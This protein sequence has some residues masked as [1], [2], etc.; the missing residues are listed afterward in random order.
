MSCE[1]KI[2]NNLTCFLL[3]SFPIVFLTSCA[4]A[5]YGTVPISSSET[6]T[7]AAKTT[8]RP[9]ER[10]I[11]KPV[12]RPVIQPFQKEQPSSGYQ[13]FKGERKYITASWYGPDFHGKP[14]ACGE[15]FNMHALT[16]AH[17]EYPFGTKLRVVNSQNSK[18]VECIV[19]DR[20]PFIAGRDLD[21]S[22]AAAKKID[23]VGPG[24]S[25]VMIEPIGRDLRYVKYIR[26]GVSDGVLTIQIGSFK[27]ESNARRLKMALELRYKNAYIMEANVGG[28]KYYRVRIG[29]YNSKGDASKI[30]GAL[31]EEGYNVL[32][33]RFEQQI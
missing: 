23:L 1:S 9:L 25:T 6:Q 33:T 8:E 10:P 18:E 31:A 20:G 13:E 7:P 24:T 28:S 2:K 12:F 19:T 16:C 21:L 3:L 14:T 5:K 4:T 26:Y 30:G 27:D 15:L 29:K 22:Y 11:E 17:K 32:V